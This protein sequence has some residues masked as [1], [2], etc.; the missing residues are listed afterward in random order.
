M[1]HLHF[2]LLPTLN[3]LYRSLT[4]YSYFF[5]TCVTWHLT[6]F[7]NTKGTHSQ[8]QR[9]S[10]SNRHIHKAVH[11]HHN[12]RTAT[13]RRCRMLRNPEHFYHVHAGLNLGWMYVHSKFQSFQKVWLYHKNCRCFWNL[14]DGCDGFE[15]ASVVRTL[16]WELCVYNIARDMQ[17]GWLGI[18]IAWF[19]FPHGCCPVIV[20]IPHWLRF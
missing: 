4:Y 10:I 11:L 6:K 16:L 12:I 17:V 8:R 1:H 13:I 5:A 7:D 2:Y 9:S 15:S 19:W 18:V 20:A 14:G 3:Q